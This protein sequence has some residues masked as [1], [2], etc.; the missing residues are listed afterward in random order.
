MNCTDRKTILTPRLWRGFTLI[1]LLVVIAIIAILASLLLPALTK[2]KE[3]GMQ[4]NCEGNERQIGL[5]VLMYADD[6]K[7]IFPIPGNPKDPAWWTAGPFTNRLGLM[8]GGEWML[9]DGY[10]NT[11]APMV[12]PYIKNPRVWVCA[13]RQRG[14]TYATAPGVFDPTITGFLSY[15]FNDIGCFC[16]VSTVNNGAPGNMVVPTPPFKLTSAKRP[17]ELLCVTEVSGSIDPK[18]SDGNGSSGDADAAWLDGFWAANSGP[19]NPTSEE[20]GRIQT[21]YGK[22]MNKVNVLYSDGHAVVTLASRLTWGNFWGIYTQ[23]PVLPFPAG[24]T[25]Y[26]NISL[27]SMDTMV[28][29]PAPE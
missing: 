12:E 13:K 15:G 27:P 17:S 5:A 7:Q 14:L 4:V 2:A 16:Q 8:C 6:Y 9:E 23:P 20:N 19:S 3:E 11:P 28:Y 18:L 1:E 26:T 10:P 22:H 25:W 24:A 29:N 21:A